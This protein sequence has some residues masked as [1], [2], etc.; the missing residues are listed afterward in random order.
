MARNK[1]IEYCKVKNY[2][3]KKKQ[4]DL[5]YRLNQLNEFLINHPNDETTSKQI[6]KIKNELEIFEMYK[7]N[8]AIVRSRLRQIEEGEKNSKYFLN[9][10]KTRGNDSTVFSLRNE[11]NPSETTENHFEILKLLKQYHEKVT[12]K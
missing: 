5:E 6:L 3:Q 11:Q 9:L 8:G 2:N 12:Q 7:T 1:T 4:I 10:A